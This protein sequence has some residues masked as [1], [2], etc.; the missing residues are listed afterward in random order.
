MQTELV[1]L[2]LLAFNSFYL[3]I[4]STIVRKKV[5]LTATGKINRQKTKECRI[6]FLHQYADGIAINSTSPKQSR[7]FF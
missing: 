7:S 2:K 5:L 3:L 1:T 6:R 4:L